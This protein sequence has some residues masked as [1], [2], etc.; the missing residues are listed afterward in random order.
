MKKLLCILQAMLGLYVLGAFVSGVSWWIF[1]MILNTSVSLKLVWKMQNA[2]PLAREN[3][4]QNIK[5][6]ATSINKRSYFELFGG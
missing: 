1:F 6:N 5:S 2:N 4:K 3:E